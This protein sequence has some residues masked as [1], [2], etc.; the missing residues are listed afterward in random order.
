MALHKYPSMSVEDY[1]ALDRSSQEARYEYYDGELRMLAGGSIYHSIIGTSVTG[2][3]YRLLHGS[4]CRV[5]N[6]DI[7]L[8]LSRSRYVHPDITVSCDQRDQG[9]G[10]MIHHPR[11]VIEV[12][13]PSTEAKD[14]GRKFTLYRECQSIQEYMM[15]DSRRVQIEVYSRDNRKWTLSTYG[16]GDEVVLESLNIR[17]PV[18][19]VYEGLDFDQQAQDEDDEDHY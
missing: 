10:E 7:R 1:L 14:R 17:F 8:Q 12:L 16:P 11:V 4:P 3:L 2:I 9:Q 13:S 6:S 5:Y 19:E 18:D 15:V